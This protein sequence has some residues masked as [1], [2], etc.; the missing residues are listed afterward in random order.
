MSGQAV[1]GTKS[2][3]VVGAESDR[4]LVWLWAEDGVSPRMNLSRGSVELACNA[5]SAE[6][7]FGLPAADKSRPRLWLRCGVWLMQ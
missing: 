7:L 2:K 4:A 5:D 1:H 6:L 3:M